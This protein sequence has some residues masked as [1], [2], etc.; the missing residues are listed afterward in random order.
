[1][2]GTHWVCFIVEKIKSY[3]FDSFGGAPNNFLL[4]QLPKP[5]ICH[6]Y[7]IRH[8]NSNLCGSCSLYFFHLIERMKI[9]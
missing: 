4:N 9:L 1:M 8:I 7:K 3:Y 5:K 6:N 2:G